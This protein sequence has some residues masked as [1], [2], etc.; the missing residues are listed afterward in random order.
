[1]ADDGRHTSGPGDLSPGDADDLLAAEYVLRLLE[2]DEITAAEHRIA[3]EAGFRTRVGVWT[4]RLSPLLAEPQDQAARAGLLR[5]IERE[6]GVAPASGVSV[7]QREEDARRM[8]RERARAEKRAAKAVAAPRKPARERRGLWGS[9]LFWRGVSVTALAA[10]A[11]LAVAVVT[12]QDLRRYY[13]PV[14]QPVAER[15]GVEVPRG[16]LLAALGPA[17]TS[18]V[19]LLSYQSGRLTAHT[20]SVETETRV[21]ELWLVPDDGSA[22]RSLGILPP[23]GE[24]IGLDVPMPSDL[25]E[26]ND[27]TILAVSLEPPGGA[28][29]GVA[30]GPIIAQGRLIRP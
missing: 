7:V 2:P 19:F 8:E 26:L 1:M 9:L 13:D 10:C 24:A 18:D 30:T 28:P 14:L 27:G 22:P 12:E 11:A 17:D 4:K 16:P 3:R 21:P 6:I 23:P 20:V 15:L 5:S 25:R 29:G